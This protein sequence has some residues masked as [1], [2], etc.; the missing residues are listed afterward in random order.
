MTRPAHAQIPNTIP[1]RPA[2]AFD[3]RLYPDPDRGSVHSG[4]LAALA[5]GTD[6]GPGA[7]SKTTPTAPA[8][9]IESIGDQPNSLLL[10]S[11]GCTRR[12]RLRR[13]EQF[14]GSRTHL[15]LDHGRP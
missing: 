4:R 1:L 5:D 7:R 12:T 3:I 8:T 15:G 14:S 13:F 10:D 6:R 11:P 9:R 2:T